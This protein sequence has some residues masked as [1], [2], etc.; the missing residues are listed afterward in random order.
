[1]V[2]LSRQLAL[3]SLTGLTLLSL[4]SP[5]WAADGAIRSIQYDP[6]S[7]HFLID[8][9]GPVK[10][11]VNTL[12]IAGHKRIIIDIDNA[13]I[14]IDLPRDSQLVSMLSRD[15]P[16]LRNVTVN[17]Y[18][19]NGRPVVRILLDIEGDLKTIRLIRNQGPRLELEVNDSSVAQ[20]IPLY[21]QPQPPQPQKPVSNGPAIEEMKSTLAVL[22]QKYEALQQEN[23]YLKAQA[24]SGTDTG[25]EAER[26]K[27]RLNDLQSE[28]SSAKLKADALNRENQNLKSQAAT[29]SQGRINSQIDQAEIN[30]LKQENNRLQ[31]QVQ[32]LNKSPAMDEMR[33]TLVTMNRRYDLLAQEN[34]GLK[35]KSA[36]N[37]TEHLKNRVSDL[38]S[39][40]SSVKLKADALGRE[41]QNLKAQTQNAPVGFD[42]HAELDQLKRDIQALRSENIQMKAASA[43]AIADADLQNL[44][45]HLG[46]A[47]QS[48]NDSIRTINEQNKEIAY[49]RNQVADVKAGMDVSAREQISQLQSAQEEKEKRIF[50]LE[51]QLAAKSG[52]PA[53]SGSA[54]EVATLKRQ[55][56]QMTSQYK[57]AVDDLNQQVKGKS[58][59]LQEREQQLTA[60]REQGR[61]A[62]E[63]Q[64]QVSSL[65]Q[66]LSDTKQSGTSSQTSSSQKI[67][68][69]QT[70]NASL[71]TELEK[72][73]RTASST[74]SSNQAD[75]KTIID[76]KDEIARL[77]KENN[78][79]KA[80]AESE[81]STA[82]NTAQVTA[83]KQQVAT[84]QSDLEKAKKAAAAKPATSGGNAAL[85]KQVGELTHQLETLRRENSSLKT[86]AASAQSARIVSS[87]P[88]AEK[89]YADGKASMLASEVEKAIDSLKT[90][91]LLDQDNSRFVLDYSVA[92]AEARQYA[93]S[94]D[95]LR[96][97]LQR[98][99]GDR[100]AYNQLGKIYLLNDQ[101]DAASQAFSRA[102]P[103]STLN[104]YATS[105]KKLGK[106]EDAEATFKLALRLNPNDSEVLFNLG[107]LYNATNKLEQ[108]RNNY[109]QAI[110]IRPDFAEAH[111]NLGLIYSK[112]GDKPQAVAHLEK[113]LKLSPEA[114]NAE[115]I[116]AY[117]QKLKA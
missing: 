21:T 100:D 59:Q 58:Q 1:M 93:E 104:N 85:Q 61:R 9:T 67:A 55:L 52:A 70:E 6:A 24:A 7:R 26:L 111:Y 99:P 22:N 62:D 47:Q 108:A 17:Q 73:K 12:S 37:D 86:S 40:L 113:F 32:Q 115:T 53:S 48:L 90:A 45:K 78:T 19:G 94:A 74:S 88:E 33:Q 10:A 2:L 114:R 42:K 105:L 16:S 117:V 72:A 82:A 91:Q 39:E 49:L 20:S 25:R 43:S 69:L 76:M 98:N 54:A 68:S 106:M 84:L 83:L 87:N 15:I 8:A 107:N 38:Q 5:V 116:R 71:K 97:Y 64:R 51:R 60:A 103:V 81:K 23:Q 65:Q 34:E 41:N 31:S 13:E 110:Q 28:L 101:G 80:Q 57:N 27:S 44:R 79:L 63:L 36:S 96:R 66:Q 112:L 75:Q 89:H 11:L 50:E 29:N 77:I 95:V 14:G 109:L 18:G 56:D 102:I 30:R 92:L 3:A 46:T 4:C 35:A